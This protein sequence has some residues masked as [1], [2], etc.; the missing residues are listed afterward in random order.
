MRVGLNGDFD[1]TR[2]ASAKLYSMTERMHI[3]D[4]RRD[5]IPRR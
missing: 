4:S 5:D 3:E 2:L 1:V